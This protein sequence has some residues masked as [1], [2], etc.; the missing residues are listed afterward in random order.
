[1]ERLETSADLARA[2]DHLMATEPRFRLIVAR[3]GLPPL[4][5]ADPGLR[6]LLRIVTDQLIS[7]KAGE[8]IWRRIEAVLS[9]VDSITI[10]GATETELCSLGLS[11]AKARCFRAA[12]AAFAAG[13][14]NGEAT[15]SEGELL[16]RLM[17]IPGIGPWTAN[18]YL[19]T[20]RRSPDAWPASDLALQHAA[21]DLLALPAQ[22]SACL[23]TRL[24]DG[25]RPFRSA[26]ALLLWSHYRSLKRL[27][28]E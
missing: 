12:A 28:R 24:A 18:I 20:V 3:H 26:A 6:S 15:L 16:D 4:R 21:M 23:M 14:F 10:S 13:R 27:P 11:R 17:E 5:H 7:L 2:V 25:W 1:M 9:P 19:L 22:P 8:A